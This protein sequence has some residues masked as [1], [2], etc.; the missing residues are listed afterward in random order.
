MSSQRLWL[1]AQ[2]RSKTDGLLA[3]AERGQG[4]KFSSVIHKLSPIDEHSHRNTLSLS[5]GVSLQYKPHLMTEHVLSSRWPAQ[6]KSVLVFLFV[7]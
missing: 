6:N 7:S 4:H 5:S 1:H 2:D 3:S